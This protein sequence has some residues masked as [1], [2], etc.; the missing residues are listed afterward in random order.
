[1]RLYCVH[2]V[3]GATMLCVL[4]SGGAD[5][6]SEEQAG[7]AESHPGNDWLQ[8][9]DGVDRAGGGALKAGKSDPYAEQLRQ[10]IA[11]EEGQE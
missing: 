6:E 4:S 10:S 7:G 3:L 9:G 5:L 11:D 8:D 1:M 2:A